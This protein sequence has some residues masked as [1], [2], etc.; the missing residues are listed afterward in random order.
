MTQA[1]VKVRKVACPSCGETTEYSPTNAF[2]PFCSQ[3][4]KLVD[5]GDW[6]TEKFRI[7]DHTPPDLPESE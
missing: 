2:R 1:A 6:A 7:P 5:L 4:C 3:R